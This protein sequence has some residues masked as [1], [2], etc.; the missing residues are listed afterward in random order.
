MAVLLFIVKEMENMISSTLMHSLQQ[1]DFTK[2]L[3]D[4]DYY[5]LLIFILFLHTG[6]SPKRKKIFL[7]ITWIWQFYHELMSA[8]GG[9]GVRGHTFHNLYSSSPLA[10]RQAPV[11]VKDGSIIYEKELKRS[12]DTP[13]K[14]CLTAYSDK[15]KQI[16]EAL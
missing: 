1:C 2:C 12:E 3:S 8:G 15:R 14:S 4:Q 16:Q 5:Y 13:H 10:W 11:L 7:K 9:G 6:I